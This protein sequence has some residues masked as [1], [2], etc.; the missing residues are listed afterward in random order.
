MIHALAQYTPCPEE[1]KKNDANR[2]E[3]TLLYLTQS[4]LRKTCV[5]CSILGSLPG[6]EKVPLLVRIAWN[7]RHSRMLLA[8][9]AK[10]AQFASNSLI[11]LQKTN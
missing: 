8:N 5:I 7:L 2:V 4:G 11:C 1:C 6:P 9:G 10:F 3:F